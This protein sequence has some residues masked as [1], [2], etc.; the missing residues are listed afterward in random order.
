MV[1]VRHILNKTTEVNPIDRNGIYIEV[2]FD[3][4]AIIN[5]VRPH[6]AIGNLY[7]AR[8]DVALFR[9]F[10]DAGIIGTGPGIFEGIPYDIEI[11]YSDGTQR[12]LNYYVDL[13]DGLRISKDGVQ[14]GL[15]LYE[16]LDWLNDRVDGFTFQSHYSGLTETEKQS[17]YKDK[18]VFVPYVINNTVT[19]LETFTTVL[20]MS[21]MVLQ[22]IK[23]IVSLTKHIALLI[24]ADVVQDIG[25]VLGIFIELAYVVAML[26][27]LIGILT[28][29]VLTVIQPIKYQVGMYLTDLL[30]ISCG[31]LGLS[32]ASNTLY[33]A[34]LKD[35]VI[36]PQRYELAI[37]PDELVSFSKMSTSVQSF[38]NSIPGLGTLLT[39]FAQDIIDLIFG[40]IQDLSDNVVSLGTG[41]FLSKLKGYPTIAIAQASDAV[42]FPSATCG[43]ILML[44]KQLINGKVVIKNGTLY[45]EPR[46][47][48]LSS[49]LYQLP[50]VRKDWVGYNTNEFYATQIF[51]FDKDL[52]DKNVIDNYIGTSYEVYQKPTIVTNDKLVLTKSMN[53]IDIPYARGINKKSLTTPEEMVQYMTQYLSYVLDATNAIVNVV[54]DIIDLVN[55]I[56]PN[57][58]NAITG[59][60]TGVINWFIDQI[61]AVISPLEIPYVT[62]PSSIIDAFSAA[63]Y[64][65]LGIA[66]ANPFVLLGSLLL[67]FDVVFGAIT[68]PTSSELLGPDRID[69]LMLENDMMDTPK[70][71]HIAELDDNRMAKLS[72]INPLVVRAK[73]FYD[74]YYGSN[75]FVVNT[76]G[77]HNQYEIIT[78]ALNK[79]GDENKIPFT[80]ED[81]ELLIADNKF[82]DDNGEVCLL[83]TMKFYVEQGFAFLTYRKKKIYTNNLKIVASEPTGY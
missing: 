54:N 25:V 4:E 77:E 50:P 3:Q 43:D 81:M 20:T 15:K 52:N 31:H 71:V 63:I 59:L 44:A 6:A 46:E 39:D 83:D 38:I 45:L 10:I 42:G 69:C 78:P 56:V 53:R 22:L 12:T 24:A 72:V 1:Q 9:S 79:P 57:I 51:S 13:T 16:G 33:S 11:T 8:E 30:E 28:D 47:Y 36:L 48:N 67:S 66:S 2:N 5:Q 64:I 65:V 37:Q 34:P 70:L 14:V 61:N 23:E 32:F 27:A 29:F 75:N 18:F 73:Y 19:G 26:V 7:F 40:A 62:I 49:A 68:I 17:I 60:F 80:A 82:L 21:T 76:N 74:N 35:L 41:I 58:L 55:D